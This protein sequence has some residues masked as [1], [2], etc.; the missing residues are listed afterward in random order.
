L[1][2]QYFLILSCGDQF[3]VLNNVE[4]ASVEALKPAL[5]A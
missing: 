2:G 4:Q 1:T 3:Q 5:G